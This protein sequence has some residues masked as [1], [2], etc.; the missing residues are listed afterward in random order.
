VRLEQ[1]D[2]D[3][4]PEPSSRQSK[5][6]GQTLVETAL[7]LPILL[8]LLVMAIDFGRVFFGWVTLNQAARIGANFASTHPDM[9]DDPDEQDRYLALI[10]RDVQAINCELDDPEDP[11]YTT[12]A[13]A[14]A[15]QPVMGDYATVRLTC[16]FTLI[17][18]L[19]G[20]IL[21]NGTLDV[22]AETTFPVRV[23]ACINCDVGAGPPPPGGGA[24]PP[25][26]CRTVPNMVGMSVAGARLAWG[27]AGFFP[28][29][30]S[31]VTDE[32][33][34]TVDSQ[35]VVQDDPNSNCTGNTAI[36]TSSVTVNTEEPDPVVDDCGATVPNLIG[37][38]V[39]Q[40]RSVWT[41]T[42]NG[43]FQPD[44]QDSRVVTAQETEPEASQPGVTCISLDSSITVEHGAPWPP[45]PPPSC[46][47]PNMVDNTRPVAHAD[48]NEAGFVPANFSPQNGNF[49][50]R[51][52]SL[53]GGDWHACGASITVSPN[54]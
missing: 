7:V 1:T 22:A 5:P 40:A 53:V 49:T 39:G 11:V 36:F 52:Q 20:H 32:D 42:F 28:S 10:E 38:T 50:V 43:D 4:G 46:R 23:A 24:P 12:P 19:A 13:G 31:P 33:T 51:R 30:F 8:I 6:R 54:P 18:P 45:P 37:T 21:G 27:S 3:R 44:N 2:S 47:V 15:A 26:Q 16:A 48:W 29:N 9:L 35:N 34:R 25:E 14:P 17:T 41:A